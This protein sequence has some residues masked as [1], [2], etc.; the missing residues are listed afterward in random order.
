MEEEKKKVGGKRVCWR[1]Y[2]TQRD[3]ASQPNGCVDHRAEAVVIINM[4]IAVI[5][6]DYSLVRSIVV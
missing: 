5:L 1:E 2:I 3:P 6:M 4:V